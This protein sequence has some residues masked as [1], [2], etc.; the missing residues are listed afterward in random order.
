MIRTAVFATLS[1]ASPWMLVFLAGVLL[2]WIVRRRS[3]LV[4]H[5]VGF[6]TTAFVLTAARRQK[7]WQKPV[8]WALPL[9]RSLVVAAVAIA[10]AEPF[11]GGPVSSS[12]TTADRVLFVDNAPAGRASEAVLSAIASLTDPQAF[13]QARWSVTRL[14]ADDASA[15][16]VSPEAG[17]VML[18]DGARPSVAFRRRLATWVRGGGRLVVLLGPQTVGPQQGAP[19]RWLEELAGVQ[20][21]TALA[22]EPEGVRA[23]VATVEPAASLAGVSVRRHVTLRM[24]QP[25]STSGGSLLSRPTTLLETTGSAEPLL[26]ARRVGRGQVLVS[27]IPLSTPARTANNV[28]TMPAGWSDLAAWPVFPAVVEEVLEFEVSSEQASGRRG[29]AAW[30]FFGRVQLSLAGFCVLVAL[31]ATAVEAVLV[32]SRQPRREP[33]PGRAVA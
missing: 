14:T 4:S 11:W 7:R 15:A 12:S 24:L 3:Q 2:P 9:V 17:V 31:L 26:I 6:A 1:F 8:R 22:H 5:R 18:A 32:G 13:P 33:G 19:D 20:I 23:V 21:G 16:A 30:S 29:P 27:A 28:D 25:A 10:A